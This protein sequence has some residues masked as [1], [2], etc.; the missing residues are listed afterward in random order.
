MISRFQNL[1][2]DFL[3]GSMNEQMFALTVQIEVFVVQYKVAC[4]I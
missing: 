3:Q 1:S 2:K 4:S